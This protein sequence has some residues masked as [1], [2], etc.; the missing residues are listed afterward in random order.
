[1]DDPTPAADNMVRCSAD[2]IPNAPKSSRGKA[3]RLAWTRAPTAYSGCILTL[4][5]DPKSV[6]LG[7]SHKP[8]LLVLVQGSDF[9]KTAQLAQS[10][11]CA[12]NFSEN[13]SRVPL[14]ETAKDFEETFPGTGKAQ[15]LDAVKGYGAPREFS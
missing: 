13:L 12:E 1:M 14:L 2:K 10:I 15:L 3:T 5:V 6:L 9:P 7:N 4:H 8:G 11:I